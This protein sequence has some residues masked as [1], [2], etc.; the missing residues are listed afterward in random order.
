MVRRRVF[1]TCVVKSP[2]I[3]AKCYVFPTNGFFGPVFKNHAL[4]IVHHQ[5]EITKTHIQISAKDILLCISQRES[6]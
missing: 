5:R 4:E 2:S 6:K 1:A 3:C